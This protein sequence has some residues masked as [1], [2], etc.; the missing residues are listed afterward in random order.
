MTDEELDQVAGGGY[1]PDGFIHFNPDGTITCDEITT[2]TCPKCGAKLFSEEA[3][4]WHIEKTHQYNNN[5][6]TK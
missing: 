5:N 2:Y 4:G 1:I 3:L 6:K